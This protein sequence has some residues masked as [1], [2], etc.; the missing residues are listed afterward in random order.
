MK[1]QRRLQD[2]APIVLDGATGTRLENLGVDVRNPLWSS[3]ALLD[4][5]G[6]ALTARVHGEY[7]A[8]GADVVIANTHNVSAPNVARYLS[9]DSEAVPLT[10]ESPTVVAETRTLN[11]RAVDVARGTNAIVAGCLASPDRPYATRSSLTA[12]AVAA[13]L[14]TQYEA[15]VEAAPD[16]IIF[17][18]LTTA[19]DLDGVAKLV[20]R[21]SSSDVPV[22]VGVVAG[23]GGTLGGVPWA[24]AVR[25]L[26]PARPTVLFVQCTAVDRVLP[27]LTTL[28]GLEDPPILGAY[29]NDGGYDA[30][31]QA[32]SG[33]R[34][35]PEAYAADARQ[36]W[37]AGGPRDR[38]LLR[39]G[40]GAHSSRRGSAARRSGAARVM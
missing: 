40:A 21:S 31:T 14:E 32:W 17:E 25:A 38:G 10:E 2:S 12:D 16:L 36:W 3:V 27:A 6:R 9:S 37:R 33:P 5:Q 26:R 7:V 29:A 8:A 30:N 13:K 19:A 24:D 1:W 4:A 22:A 34:L 39:N 35:S 28:A 11:R 20:S 23:D 15:L 18:M